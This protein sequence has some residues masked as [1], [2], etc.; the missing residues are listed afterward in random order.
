MKGKMKTRFKQAD[1][2]ALITLGLYF[3]F[4]VWWYSFAY[5][6]GSKPVSEYTYILGFPSWFFYSCIVGYLLIS[7]LLWF[8]VKIFFVE[9]PL[10]EEDDS[11]TSNIR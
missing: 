2:E 11:E 7:F 10:E 8:V 6:L 9:I 1:K 3:V 5:G 4:F